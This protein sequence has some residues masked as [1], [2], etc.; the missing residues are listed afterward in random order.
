M[1]PRGAAC[2]GEMGIF[3]GLS[4]RLLVVTVAAVM[5]VEVVVFIPSVARFRL[6]YLQERI[7][8]AHLAVLAV[9]AAP[10]EMPT[11]ALEHDLLAGA[12]VRNIVLRRGASRALMLSGPPIDQVAASFDLREAGSATLIRDALS[13]LVQPPGGE[14][15]RVIGVPKGRPDGVLE[16]TLD[17]G[18]LRAAMID[19]GLR[20][21]Q[22]SL[23]ISGLAAAAVFLLIRR[24]VVAPLL[25]VV[26]NVTRFK[27]APEDP[28][29][30]IRPSGRGG[31]VAEAESAIAAMQ[32]DV[33]RAFAERARLAS[34]GEAV[35]KISHDLRNLLSAQHLMLDRLEHSSDPTVARVMPKMIASLDR[36]IRLCQR[37]LDYGRAEEAA[38][39]LREVALAPLVA[40]VAETVGVGEGAVALETDMDDGMTVPAD[41]EQLFRM[42]ANLMRNAREA[43]DSTGRR[44]TIRV[45]AARRDGWAAIRV[46]DTGPGLPARAREHLFK[47]FQGSARRGGTGLGL[48]IAHDLARAHGGTLALVSSTTEG[49]V[50]EICLP[51]Q[52]GAAGLRG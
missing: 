32:E 26:D 17:A 49:T 8:R 29:R 41:P 27:E 21:L 3:R 19:Y 33:R 40:E 5:A 16:I 30:I 45:S 25:R 38:P 28:A 35:A 47:P 13:R 9:T 4:G 31:E 46:A 20:I 6:D 48:T 34:L 11:P 37:T 43:I 52:G 22:L 14:I 1:L 10:D 50:I 51:A 39:D 7:E 36:A 2:G 18:A 23:I 44:G 24:L 42:L 15:I 12:G